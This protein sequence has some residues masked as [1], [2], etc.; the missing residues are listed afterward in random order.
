MVTRSCQLARIKPP[1]FD[2]QVPFGPVTEAVVNEHF[3]DSETSRWTR[4]HRMFMTSVERARREARIDLTEL[5]PE[6]VGIFGAV[7]RPATQWWHEFDGQPGL[8]PLIGGL[9]AQ[10]TGI[11]AA[12]Y[13][14]QGPI[15]SITNACVSGAYAIGTAA[16]AVDLGDA[17]LIFAGAHEA[18]PTPGVLAAYREAGLLSF[19]EPQSAVRPGRASGTAFSEGAVMLALEKHGSGRHAPLAIHADFCV[20]NT[21]QHILK[22]YPDRLQQLVT[23]IIARN[24][25]APGDVD[26]IVSHG[27]GCL[28]SDSAERTAYESVFGTRSCPPVVSIKPIYGH[29]LAAASATNIAA[30]VA[31]V[32]RNRPAGVPWLPEWC[33]IAGRQCRI[34][35]AVSLGMGGQNSVTLIHSPDVVL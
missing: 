19:G 27:N 6:R 2:R 15:T 32:A 11:A 25:I 14:I 17:D 3:P 5:P 18:M 10:A 1:G 9:P 16:R 23:E 21:G 28:M 4:E 35:L 7:G 8:G 26:V 13:G 22:V 31:M 34:A 12:Y 33:E 24:N 29:G 30:A 20:G